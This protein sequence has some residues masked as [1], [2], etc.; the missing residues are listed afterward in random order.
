MLI[1]KEREVFDME[2]EDKFV[3]SKYFFTA[4]EH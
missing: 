3:G 4:D 1:K 2:K